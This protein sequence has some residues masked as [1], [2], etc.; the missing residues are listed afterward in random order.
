[1]KGRVCRGGQWVLAQRSLSLSEWL[2]GVGGDLSKGEI[3]GSTRVHG[4]DRPGV[5]QGPPL[6]P[7]SSLSH[8]HPR[9]K[10]R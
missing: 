4:P 9:G 1:M 5:N 8:G 2:A 3:L 10:G 6:T 7:L